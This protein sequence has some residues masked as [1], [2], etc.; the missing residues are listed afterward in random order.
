MK[1]IERN[2]YHITALQQ[3]TSLSSLHKAPV[4]I[5]T[6]QSNDRQPEAPQATSAC[7]TSFKDVPASKRCTLMATM[8]LTSLVGPTCNARAA[9]AP[10]GGGRYLGG[11]RNA[12]TPRTTREST[13]V[14]YA[15]GA[16]KAG[17]ASPRQFKNHRNQFILSLCCIAQNC[18]ARRAVS[19]SPGCNLHCAWRA[20]SISSWSAFVSHGAP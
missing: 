1:N 6:V 18:T 3:I 20:L 12:K 5:F 14:S 15:R 17:V 8:V 2:S 7:E 4:H 10:S 9:T 11:L 19:A 13:Q 16:K